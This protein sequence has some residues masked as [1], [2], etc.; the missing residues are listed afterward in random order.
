MLDRTEVALSLVVVAVA[1]LLSRF[2]QLSPI[3]TIALLVGAAVVQV[4]CLPV[5]SGGHEPII[6]NDGG[7]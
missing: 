6:P 4:L 1:F 7:R 2:I 5:V 3:E